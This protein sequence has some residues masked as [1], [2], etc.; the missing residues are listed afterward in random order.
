[1]A[2]QNILAMTLSSDVK[3]EGLSEER[4]KAQIPILRQYIAYWREYPDMFVEFLCGPNNSENFSLFFY[5]CMLHSLVRI[6]NHSY[7]Y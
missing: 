3:K 7:Q 2:L 5:I 1:M 4:I 6:L